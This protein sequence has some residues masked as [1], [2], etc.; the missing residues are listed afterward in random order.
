MS[1][2]KCGSEGEEERRVSFDNES[3]GDF[4]KVRYHVKDVTLGMWCFAEVIKKMKVWCEIRGTAGNRG[5]VNVMNF[6]MDNVNGGF[7]ED[8]GILPSL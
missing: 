7:N 3:F 6:D 2:C 4:S 1:S 5:D 8:N